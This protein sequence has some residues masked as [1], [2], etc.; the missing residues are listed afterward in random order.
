MRYIPST[1]TI[2]A[3]MLTLVA[4]SAAMILQSNAETV[5]S[6]YS[7]TAPKDCHVRSTGNGVDDSTVRVCP[8]KAGLI[9]LISEDDLREAVSVGRKP[10]GGL[11]G[12]GSAV[13]VWSLQFNDQ[14]SGMA[15][16][17][18]QAL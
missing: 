2:L 11:E 17:Q 6:S 5:G 8:G 16:S 4:A 15:L 7:S 1:V 12:T 18:W 9:V 14:H 3:T 10:P 13:R